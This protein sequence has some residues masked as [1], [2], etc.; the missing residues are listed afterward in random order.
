VKVVERNGFS[1]IIEVKHG[2][3]EEMELPVEKV[4][5]I[6]SEWMGYFLYFESMLSSI[7]YARDKYLAPGGHL[8]PSHANLYGFGFGYDQMKLNFWKH[9]YGYDLRDVYSRPHTG[10]ALVIA[11]DPAF[12]ATNRVIVKTTN[13]NNVKDCELDFDYKGSFIVTRMGP[14]DCIGFAFDCLFPKNVVLTTGCESQPTHWYQTCFLLKQSFE[15]EV[16]AQLNFELK[17]SRRH[18]NKR[19]YQLFLKV[20]HGTQVSQAT[21]TV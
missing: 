2:K 15:V 20:W 16:G 1:N 13:V 9:C 11:V 6:I 4:D 10:H 21:Y 14:I 5:I 7:I 8:F 18:S 12:V 3:L 19:H 17:A